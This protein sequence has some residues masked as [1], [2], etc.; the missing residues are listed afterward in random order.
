LRIAKRKKDGVSWM[1]VRFSRL[2]RGEKTSKQLN[3]RDSW[4]K[5]RRFEKQKS[6]RGGGDAA[7]F[8][9]A[10]RCRKFHAFEIEMSCSCA[11]QI[12]S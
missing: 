4:K 6:I 12:G 5:F 9:Y 3:A 11:G 7:L 1:R 10:T 8:V 2:A